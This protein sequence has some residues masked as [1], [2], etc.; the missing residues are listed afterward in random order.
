MF[1]N[2]LE[3]K[4]EQMEKKAKKKRRNKQNKRRG[5][6]SLSQMPHSTNQVAALLTVY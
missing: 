3:G 2:K 4:K 6:G 5:K 1:T